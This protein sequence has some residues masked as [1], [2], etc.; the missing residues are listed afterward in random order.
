MPLTVDDFLAADVELLSLRRSLT[1]AAPESRDRK[2]L[3]RLLAERE[4]QAREHWASGLEGWMT[5][6]EA[7]VVARELLAERGGR[8]AG[9]E[10]REDQLVFTGARTEQTLALSA[11]SPV[12]ARAHWPGYLDACPM[13]P[14][15]EGPAPAATPP[16]QLDLLADGRD[17]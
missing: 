7:S 11:T 9:V 10:V 4:Q 12:R 6:D 1:Y 14:V 16:S 3:L 5:P 17:G 13:A 2:R 15:A 8:A